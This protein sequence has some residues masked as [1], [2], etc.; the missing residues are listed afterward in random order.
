MKIF[1]KYIHSHDNCSFVYIFVVVC[2]CLLIVWFVGLYLVVHNDCVSLP[3][4]RHAVLPVRLL[5]TPRLSKYY[6]FV[7][8][9]FV[10]CINCLC[11]AVDSFC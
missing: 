2:V 10:L 11:H 1:L 9:G 5:M 8:S 4:G 7:S 6:M 3:G